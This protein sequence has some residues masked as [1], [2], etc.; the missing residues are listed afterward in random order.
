MASVFLLAAMVGVLRGKVN[1]GANFAWTSQH[2]VTTALSTYAAFPSA[3][4]HQEQ[5]SL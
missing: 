2:V 5:A 1:S 3:S 4:C